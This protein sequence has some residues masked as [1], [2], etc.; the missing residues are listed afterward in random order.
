M[1]FWFRRT[2]WAKSTI[3]EAIIGA[4][5]I[6]VPY[7]GNYQFRENLTDKGQFE[8]WPPFLRTPMKSGQK[9][10]EL[11]L[12]VRA[13]EVETKFL[14]GL[15]IKDPVG[16]VTI[17]IEHSRCIT[18][19]NANLTAQKLFEFHAASQGVGYIV[20]FFLGDPCPAFEHFPGSL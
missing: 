20:W 8:V 10:A 17:Q 12:E 15:N 6:V 7:H 11:K 1:S 3:L 2:A 4:H 16:T 5:D 14:A 18:G 9:R 19:K 13:N